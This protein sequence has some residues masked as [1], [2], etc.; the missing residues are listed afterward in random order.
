[1]SV[2]ELLAQKIVNQP[3]ATTPTAFGW[4][5]VHARA[6]PVTVFSDDGDFTIKPDESMVFAAVDGKLR[7][8]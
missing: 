7:R 8:V 5:R 3:Y 4:L 2:E 1:M 6:E